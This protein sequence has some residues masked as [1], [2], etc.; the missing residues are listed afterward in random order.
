MC[1]GNQQGL[2]IRVHFV[3]IASEGPANMCLP[4]DCPPFLPPPPVKSQTST[5]NILFLSSAEDGIYGAGLG[6][7][8]TLL[9]FPGSL[10]GIHAIELL[11]D[12]PP[13]W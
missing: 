11:F 13:S 2:E 6:Y 8:G 5:R 9:I 4:I 12:F 7:F 3:S 1:G 10:P